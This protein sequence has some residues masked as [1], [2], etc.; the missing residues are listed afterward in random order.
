MC[1]AQH[2]NLTAVRSNAA[3]ERRKIVTYVL[4]AAKF[5]QTN[6]VVAGVH[7]TRIGPFFF[8]AMLFFFLS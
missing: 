1:A 2:V 8:V 7:S 4:G 6:V 5:E 3:G